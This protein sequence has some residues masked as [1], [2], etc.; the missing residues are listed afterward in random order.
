MSEHA[1]VILVQD[2]DIITEADAPHALCCRISAVVEM[3]LDGFL[4]L[5]TPALLAMA[6]AAAVCFG[7]WIARAG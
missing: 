5:E 4:M 2:S 3:A 6:A 1:T 7:A